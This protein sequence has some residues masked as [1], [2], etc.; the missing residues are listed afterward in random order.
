MVG[1]CCISEEIR[2]G[3]RVRHSAMLF[4]VCGT[5]WWP[6]IPVCCE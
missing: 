6:P 5:L 1:L 3:V 4:G 2:S